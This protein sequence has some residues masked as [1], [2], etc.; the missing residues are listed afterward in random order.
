M[1]L[2][3][4]STME[5]DYEDKLAE[6]GEYDLRIQSAEYKDTKEKPGKPIRKIVQCMIVFD[7]AEGEGLAPIT[8]VLVFPNDDEEPKTRRLFMQNITRFYKLF[9]LAHDA[10]VTDFNGAT[11]RCYVNQKE[12]D[13]G[14]MR[15]R[16][17]L[18]RVDSY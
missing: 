4:P 12:D 18:P 2:I 1:P 7:G 17:R 3:N 10:E 9:G 8:H 15:N 5:E 11:A 14:V 16:L 6:V 13:E